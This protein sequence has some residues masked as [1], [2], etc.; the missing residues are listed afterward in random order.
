MNHV[1][2]AKTFIPVDKYQDVVHKKDRVLV[3]FSPKREDDCI[4]CIECSV[5]TD[6]FT[7][8]AVEN[9]YNAYVAET[10]E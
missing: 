6:G 1:S 2:F 7:S 3:H 8:E 9:M 10:Q 5:P 4:T